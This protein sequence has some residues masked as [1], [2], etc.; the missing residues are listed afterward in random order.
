MAPR[1]PLNGGSL[2][3]TGG[4]GCFAG[5]ATLDAGIGSCGA[6]VGTAQGEVLDSKEGRGPRKPR[7]GRGNKTATGLPPKMVVKLQ[8]NSHHKKEI[9]DCELKENPKSA[10]RCSS[11]CQ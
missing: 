3:L 5:I 1:R 6:A 8:Q 7:S 10:I 9:S 11:C 2:P 4:A